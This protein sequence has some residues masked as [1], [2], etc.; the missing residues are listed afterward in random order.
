ML[1]NL[2]ESTSIFVCLLLS[3]EEGE[4]ITLVYNQKHNTA[5]ERKMM[6]VIIT[7]VIFIGSLFSIVDLSFSFEIDSIAG[8]I[9]SAQGYRFDRIE[10]G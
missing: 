6:K 9:I 7:E 10:T 2:V 4:L 8:C 5:P 3:E 1:S